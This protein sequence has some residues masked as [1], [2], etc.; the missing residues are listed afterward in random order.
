[1]RKFLV[2]FLIIIALVI[3]LQNNLI[4][5]QPAVKDPNLKVEALVSGISFPTSM[6][7]LDNNNILVLEKD[8]N[9]RLASNGVLQPQPLLSINVDSKNERGLLGIEKV[10]ENIF[11]YATVKDGQVQNRIYKYT[12][13]V[14]PELT[15][16]EVFMDLPGTI[17]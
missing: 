17:Q 10:G 15:N 9:V 1:M 13:G 16:Q 3:T 11:L 14:G 7:F 5:A 6:L 4:Y 2:F 12:L 8:G